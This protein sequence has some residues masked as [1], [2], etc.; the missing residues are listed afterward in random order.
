VVRGVSGGGGGVGGGGRGARVAGEGGC[1]VES[2]INTLH[3]SV[4]HVQ[5]PL[6]SLCMIPF[7][8]VRHGYTSV[9]PFEGRDGRVNGGL[10]QV[11]CRSIPCTPCTLA[12]VRTRVRLAYVYAR[13][14][15]N[16]FRTHRMP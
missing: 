1:V 13:M 8:S 6:M 3:A 12:C 2:D 7:V 10:A 14:H 16:V 4:T 5:H 11:W 9:D 15:G